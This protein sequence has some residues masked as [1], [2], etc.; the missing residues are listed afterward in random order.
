MSKR[1]DE[2][3]TLVQ[4]GWRP[5]RGN[6]QGSVYESLDCN[7]GLLNGKETRTRPYWF[8]RQDLYVCVGCSRKCSLARPVGFQPAL[9][10]RYPQKKGQRFTL[11]PEEL[12]SRKALLNVAEAAYCLNVS[13]GKIYLDIAEG[14]LTALKENPKRISA[15]EIAEKMRDFDI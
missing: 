11:T 7:H 13:E 2:I 14:K 1:I 15:K 3:V 10:V 9:P 4:A 12:V 6:V 5:Y 8:V